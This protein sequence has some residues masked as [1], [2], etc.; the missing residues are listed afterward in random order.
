MRG[1]S[2][3]QEK[4]TVAVAA[5]AC[6]NTQNTL[7]STEHPLSPFPSPEERIKRRR[8]KRGNVHNKKKEEGGREKAGKAPDHNIGDVNSRHSRFTS[9]GTLLSTLKVG[10]N[11]GQLTGNL[12]VWG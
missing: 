4:N 2:A 1:R 7:V 9:L 5:A 11:H 3:R 8:G 6:T 10:L 12:R